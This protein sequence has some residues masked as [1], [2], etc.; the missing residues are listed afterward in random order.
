MQPYGG[1]AEHG[2]SSGGGYHIDIVATHF[3]ER[4][5][6]IGKLLDASIH[7]IALLTNLPVNTKHTPQAAV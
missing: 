5:H 1:P 2:E 7:S 3:L 6:H 4:E